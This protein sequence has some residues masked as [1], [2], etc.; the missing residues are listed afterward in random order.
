MDL[1]TLYRRTVKAWTDRVA[2][3]GPDQ[4]D[5]PTPC[6]EWDVRAL[7][8][9]V[10]GEDLWTVPLMDGATIEEVGSRFDG[11]LLG[12]DP[13]ERALVAAEDAVRSV[14]AQL[15]A[16]RPVHLSYGDEAA[17]EYV[18]QLAAD[19]LV[20]GWD[21]AVATGGDRQLD[22]ELVSEVATWFA[23]REEAYRAAGAVGARAG[24]GDD[25]Q[26]RLLSAFGRDPGWSVPR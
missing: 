3:V 4:W 23:E 24:G 25:A 22:P 20:H 12:D 26:S 6:S 5:A 17:D 13:V 8:N 18:R 2:A 14:A 1:D 15:P 16:Q 10:A 11:D 21:L 9:H 7:V 19:H